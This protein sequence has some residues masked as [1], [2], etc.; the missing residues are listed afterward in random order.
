MCSQADAGEGPGG[1]GL[2]SVKEAN[3]LLLVREI[4]AA[5][6]LRTLSGRSRRLTVPAQEHRSVPRYTLEL[7]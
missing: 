1:F 6:S 3:D 4:V 5:D 7:R 2:A